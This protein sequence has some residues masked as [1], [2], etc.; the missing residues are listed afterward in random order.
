VRSLQTPYVGGTNRP[1]ET[2]AVGRNR[3]TETL[4]GLGA[5]HFLFAQELPVLLC[6]EAES[7]SDVPPLVPPF[8]T[9]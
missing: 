6:F 8:F 4:F 3:K 2:P 5:S 9:K 7:S 1:V